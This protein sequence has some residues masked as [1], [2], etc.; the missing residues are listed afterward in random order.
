MGLIY[1][2][3]YAT[4]VAANGPDVDSGLPRVQRDGLPAV[5]HAELIKPGLQMMHFSTLDNRLDRARYSSR[6]W[7]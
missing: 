4:I 2:S 1:E 5:Q 3:A 6:G 7:T